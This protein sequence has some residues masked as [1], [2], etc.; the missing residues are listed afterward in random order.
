LSLAH[1]DRCCVGI[2]QKGERLRKGASACLAR[3]QSN[4]RFIRTL[5]HHLDR[6]FAPG[7]VDEIR[8]VHPDPR[9]K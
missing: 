2:D 9:P 6:Y 3:D 1:P 5:I 7:E 8:I 4:A